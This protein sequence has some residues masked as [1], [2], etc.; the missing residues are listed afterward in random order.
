YGT[1]DNYN[2][3]MFERFHIDFAKEGWRAS[4]KRDE[5]PQ[6][7][8]WLSWQKKVASV[9]AYLDSQQPMQDVQVDS[10]AKGIRITKSPHQPHQLISSVEETHDAAGLTQAIKEYINSLV[11]CRENVARHNLPFSQID[12]YHNFRFTQDEVGYGEALPSSRGN[13]EVVHCKPSNEKHVARFD[14]VVVYNNSD[15]AESTGLEGDKSCCP[16]SE[17]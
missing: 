11:D 3:E 14:T 13:T 12:I 9:S 17:L 8:Q 2:T 15:E 6:M 5:R 4:N 7:A 1:T 16:R 10:S